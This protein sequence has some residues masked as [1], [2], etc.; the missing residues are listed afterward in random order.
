AVATFLVD[1]LDL[2]KNVRAMEI[3][4][5][6]YGATAGLKMA[7][8]FV[9]LN[10]DKKA[11]VIASDI[12]R[13]GINTPGEVTQGAGAVAMMVSKDPR[14]LKFNREEVYMTKNVGDFWRPTFSK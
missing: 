11:L 12:A 14:I 1:L 10:P 8:G 9:A 6:C 5:A 2:P 13:Y 4:E 3:K 7:E